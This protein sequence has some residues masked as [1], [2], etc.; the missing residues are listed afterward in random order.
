MN[1]RDVVST[2]GAGDALFAAFIHFYNRTRDPYEALQK[3]IIFASF[4]RGAVGGAEGFI[5]EA[6][7]DTL[8]SM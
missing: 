4:K 7:L 8:Q 1:T 3:A 6:Q 5:T 2:A